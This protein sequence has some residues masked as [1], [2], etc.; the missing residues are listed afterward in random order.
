MDTRLEDYLRSL[1]EKIEESLSKNQERTENKLE[2]LKRN[3]ASL[4]N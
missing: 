1:D 4:K 3:Q 2:I